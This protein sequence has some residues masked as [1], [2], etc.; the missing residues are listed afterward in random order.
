MR[1]GHEVVQ[2]RSPILPAGKE[3]LQLPPIERKTRG[4]GSASRQDPISNL[5]NHGAQIMGGNNSSSARNLNNY[6][7]GS[8]NESDSVRD[9]M[10]I[11]K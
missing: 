8:K 3:N 6:R 11:G 1:S 7:S 5:R 10:N 4:I 9:S 2:H